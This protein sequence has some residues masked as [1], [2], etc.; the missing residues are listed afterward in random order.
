MNIN[1]KH[2]KYLKWLKCLK[3]LKCLECSKFK[4]IKGF[5]KQQVV[6]PPAM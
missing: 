3:Y 6:G 5:M 2:L 1:T 4:V